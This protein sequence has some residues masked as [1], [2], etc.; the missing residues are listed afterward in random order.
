[1]L[2]QGETDPAVATLRVAVAAYLGET[3]PTEGASDVF[4]RHLRMAIREVQR[5]AGLPQRDGLPHEDV[6]AVIA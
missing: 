5:R 1:M 3:V 4:D 2:R 6:L